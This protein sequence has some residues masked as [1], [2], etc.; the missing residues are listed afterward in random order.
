M[1]GSI[2]PI[3]DAFGQSVVG[4]QRDG[5]K[6]VDLPKVPPAGQLLL[7]FRILLCLLIEYL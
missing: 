4:R 2:A 5:P 1:P 6:R 3:E 7:L